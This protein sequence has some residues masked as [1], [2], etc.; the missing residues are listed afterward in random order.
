MIASI[1][2]FVFC[3][4]FLCFTMLPLFLKDGEDGYKK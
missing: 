3:V 1:A 2:I 4:V